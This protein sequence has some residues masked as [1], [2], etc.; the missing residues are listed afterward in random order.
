[1]TGALEIRCGDRFQMSIIS[2]RV[3]KVILVCFDAFGGKM[4]FCMCQLVYCSL[5]E[6]IQTPPQ[7][8][9]LPNLKKYVR[10]I[11]IYWM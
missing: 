4:Y 1:M 5:K 8:T 10:N 11:F 6:V 7:R 3:L 9:L 2:E